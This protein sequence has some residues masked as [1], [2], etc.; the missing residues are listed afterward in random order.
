MPVSARF[1][2]ISGS[3]SAFSCVRYSDLISNAVVGVQSGMG[4][5]FLVANWMMLVDV[6]HRS[7]SILMS[8]CEVVSAVPPLVAFCSSTWLF[9]VQVELGFIHNCHKIP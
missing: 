2:M 8:V 1:E 9:R 6:F 7:Q 5:E 4:K 3:N